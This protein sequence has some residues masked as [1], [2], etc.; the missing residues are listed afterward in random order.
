MQG[1]E[2]AAKIEEA[3]Q[4]NK[5]AYKKALLEQDEADKDREVKWANSEIANLKA[6]AT[7]ERVKI[8]DQIRLAT[9]E[10]TAQ[11]L[12]N[13]LAQNEHGMQKLLID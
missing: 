13:Q 2:A 5:T 7:I 1:L 4:R 9:N 6:Q 12:R 3:T 11:R 8:T 10:G